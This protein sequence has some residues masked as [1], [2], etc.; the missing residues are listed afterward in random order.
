M[1]TD[2]QIQFW[3]NLLADMESDQRFMVERNYREEIRI[4]VRPEI[5]DLLRRFITG[6][7]DIEKL[8]ST[9]DAKTRKEWDVFGLKGL[10][11]AM[12]LN[13]LVK[14]IPDKASLTAELR[15]VMRVPS[16]VDQARRQMQGFQSFLEEQIETGQ[17]TRRLV[18]P[19]RMPVLISACW[20]MQ[21]TDR[22]PIFYQSKRQ[23]LEAV[24]LYIPHQD[25][26]ENY[27]VFRDVF[28]TLGK[29]LQ[30]TNW[31]LESLCAWYQMQYSGSTV[32]PE[33]EVFAS[34][35]ISA[36]A[37][38]PIMHH[39]PEREEIGHTQVQML[40]AKLGKHFGRK[41]WIA[42]NDHNRAWNNER[43]GDY[44]LGTLPEFP[45]VGRKTQRMIELIDVLWLEG[46]RIVAAFEVEKTTSI[47]SGLLRLSDVSITLGNFNFPLYIVAPEAR[48]K[49][50]RE[51]L[52]RATF[53]S[54]E[55]H[56]RC[57]FFSYEQ[58]IHDFETMIS[59]AS[60]PQV[61][62]KLAEYVADNTYED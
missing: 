53:Q 52:S 19:A 16:S 18:E 39:L 47:Y 61:I 2:E 26:A 6:K 14:H 31:R 23:T 40:L 32:A 55:L 50:V 15:S 28:L 60:D 24:G 49:D 43:L 57:G 11:G 51:Q 1:L 62:G 48:L 56:R 3:E 8:R 4:K 35:T 46:R 42:A 30:L 13:K 58:L 44:S 17:T 5:Q 7:I 36:T 33:E 29:S 9:F 34:E 21:D 41:I 20:H 25:S 22:W 38:I 12:F 45:G 54:L 59:W 27:L 10:S 37:D